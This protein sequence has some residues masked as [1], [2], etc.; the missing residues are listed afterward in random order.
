M[1]WTDATSYAQGQRGKAPQTAWEGK[2]GN[3][4]VWVS[5]GHKMY[6][7]R[8]VMNCEAVKIKEL[9]LGSTEVGSEQARNRALQEVWQAARRLQIVMEE[10]GDMANEVLSSSSRTPQ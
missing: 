7:D 2:L 5:C 4:R 6:P 9:D 3:V 8:W 1:N 10:I